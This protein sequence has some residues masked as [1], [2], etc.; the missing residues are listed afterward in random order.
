MVAVE[1]AH[2][3]AGF[4]VAL[5][6]IFRG[7]RGEGLQLA[8]KHRCPAFEGDDDSVEKRRSDGQLGHFQPGRRQEEAKM[9]QHVANDYVSASE[10]KG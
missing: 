3:H 4:D 10:G 1:K 7:R 9:V 8:Q 5:R 2:L 6:N